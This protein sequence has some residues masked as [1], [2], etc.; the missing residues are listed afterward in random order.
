MRLLELLVLPFPLLLLLPLEAAIRLT[1]VASC[2]V[3]RLAS[4]L[5]EGSFLHGLVNVPTFSFLILFKSFLRLFH[6][7]FQFFQ[8]L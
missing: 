8:I 1:A 2:L 5:A 7:L 4:P 3:W 6:A